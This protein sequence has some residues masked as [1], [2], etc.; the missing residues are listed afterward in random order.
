M[1]R[2][3]A[4]EELPVNGFTTIEVIAVLIIVGVIA[5]VVVSRFTGTS[6]YSV[7]SVAEQLKNHLRYAQTRAMNSNVIW[8][9][10]FIDST[11]YTIFKD[12]DTTH[13]RNPSRRRLGPCGSEW[14]RGQ[15]RG[16]GVQHCFL[17]RLGKTLHGRNRQYTSK[18]SEVHYGIGRRGNGHHSDH[19]EHGLYPM[20]TVAWIRCQRAFTLLEV[21]I[22]LIVVGIVAAM[23]V[24]FLG[25]T[26]T[27]SVRSVISAQDHAQLNQVM[28]NITA[29]FKKLCRTRMTTPPGDPVQ[30]CGR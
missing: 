22:S 4:N 28:E 1:K 30:Q 6:T 17:R 13:N 24:P 20:K 10:H 7:P 9:I 16:P 21:I 19:A 29:D 25:T 27:R 2:S 12:A 11:H 15:P 14:S 18:W 8:G 26:L 3:I 23:M 5:A